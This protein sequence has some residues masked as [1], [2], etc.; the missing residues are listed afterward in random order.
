VQTSQSH[1]IQ[2][3]NLNTLDS[4]QNIVKIDSLRPTIHAYSWDEKYMRRAIPTRRDVPAASAAMSAVSLMPGQSAATRKSSSA[5]LPTPLGSGSASGAPNLP[6]GFTNTF[7]SRFC[8]VL[9]S[10]DGTALVPIP[11]RNTIPRTTSTL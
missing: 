7:T 4:R 1:L 5:R 9:E 3:A 10:H 8:L 6:K 11:K 2:K